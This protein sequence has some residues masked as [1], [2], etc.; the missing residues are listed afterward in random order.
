M[1]TPEITLDYI[2]SVPL[3]SAIEELDYDTILSERIQANKEN[4]PLWSGS[5]ESPL[6]KNEELQAYREYTI[7]QI[8]NVLTRQVLPA[9]AK[10]TALTNLAILF[11]IERGDKGDEELLLALANRQRRSPATFN[12]LMAIAKDIAAPVSIADVNVSAS[13]DKRT[14]TFYLL[15]AGQTALDATEE[16][17][18]TSYLN[19]TRNKLMD[20]SAVIGNIKENALAIAITAFHLPGIANPLTLTGNIREAVYAW[21][22]R[23]S[24]LGNTIYRENLRR[25][26]TIEG[27]EYANVT[28]PANE[29]YPGV[30]GTLHKFVKEDSDDGVRITLTEL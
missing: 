21:I 24:K 18:M 28:L 17:E 23:N 16:V 20:T 1:T 29:I 4:L 25:A 8:Q 26:A 6:Y 15:K 27:V 2:R 9:H 30:L 13:E 7:R 11:G 3:S 5:P 12:G 14:I 22:D 19:L 10:D